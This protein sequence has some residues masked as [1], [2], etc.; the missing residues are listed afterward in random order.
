MQFLQKYTVTYN[1]LKD[2]KGKYMQIHFA[3]TIIFDELTLV[4]QI[5][6]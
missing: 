6:S 3:Q 2:L 5:P 4:L 1:H